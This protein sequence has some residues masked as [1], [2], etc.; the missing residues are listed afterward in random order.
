MGKEKIKE[1]E[2]ERD[3]LPEVEMPKID[4][5]EFIGTKVKV[6]SAKII[7]TQFGRAIKFETEPVFDAGTEDKPNL[8]KATK[9]LGLHQNDEGVWGIG[10]DSKTSEFFNKWKIKMH[11]DMIGKTVTLQATEPKNGTQFLTFN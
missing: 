11:K 4:V 1:I 5:T 2:F 8:I 6:V 7:A 9:L 10:K 3:S